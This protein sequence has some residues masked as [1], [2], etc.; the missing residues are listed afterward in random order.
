MSFNI[1]RRYCEN[2]LKLKDYDSYFR[3]RM[4]DLVSVRNELSEDS[5]VKEYESKYVVPKMKWSHDPYEMSYPTPDYIYTRKL[6]AL[7]AVSL[8]MSYKECCFERRANMLKSDK[9]TIPS[10]ITIIKDAIKRDPYITYAELVELDLELDI[11]TEL[12]HMIE[13]SELKNKWV[14]KYKDKLRWIM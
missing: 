6:E 7:A 8:I 4:A 9:E 1:Y 2:P 3:M 12:E 13:T 11:A 5:Y 14:G 10:I